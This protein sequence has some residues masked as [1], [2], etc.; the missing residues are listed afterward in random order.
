MLDRIADN[1]AEPRR[2]ALRE[3]A[4]VIRAWVFRAAGAHVGADVVRDRAT[5]ALRGPGALC[6]L[7]TFLIGLSA[8]GLGADYL[9]GE[10]TDRATIAKDCA[11]AAKALTEQQLARTELPTICTTS[12]PLARTPEQEVALATSC[13]AAVKSL[14]EQRLDTDQ[15]AESCTKKKRGGPDQP[16]PPTAQR[17]VNSVVAD[18]GKQLGACLAAASTREDRTRCSQIDRALKGATR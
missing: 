14:D 17:I 7:A 12:T 11:A 4:A 18:L 10:R 6:L 16:P 3:E 15:L 1:A 9:A 2:A 13:A 5:N 8:F